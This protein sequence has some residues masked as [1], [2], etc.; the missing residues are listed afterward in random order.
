MSEEI[1]FEIGEKYE[2]MKGVFEVIAIHRDSMDIR[3]ESGEE[4]STPIALQQRIIERMQHEK[5]LAK[6]QQDQKKKAK[7]SQ[8]KKSK[9][10]E[11]LAADDFSLAVA[12]TTW[13]GRGQLGGAVARQLKTDRFKFNSW[14]VLR[15]PEVHWLDIKRQKREDLPLQAKFYTRLDNQALYA[16]FHL[17]INASSSSVK[18][19]WNVWLTWM[20]QPE[21]EAWLK[22]QCVTRELYLIDLSGFAFVG[23][24]DVQDA[25]WNHRQPDD[26]VR[27]VDS[28]GDF[29]ENFQNA[30]ADLRIEKRIPKAEAI[31]KGQSIAADLAALFAGLLPLYNAAAS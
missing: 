1:Q 24:I 18:A 29:L 4:I 21:N 13:R 28:L 15:K 11:G 27:P 31:E 9:P 25:A 3:W 19:D 6:A 30:E 7:T 2:N 12:N 8:S 14:A 5:E 20:K 17:P 26:Q 16:G 22:D 10:F 23:R